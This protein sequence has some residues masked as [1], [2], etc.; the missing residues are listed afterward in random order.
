MLLSKYLVNM[1]FLRGPGLGALRGPRYYEA[2]RS[3]VE[4]E[5]A[6]YIGAAVS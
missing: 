3:L 5:L 1:V 4:D 6:R 2:V